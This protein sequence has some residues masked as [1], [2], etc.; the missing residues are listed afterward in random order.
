[1][2]ISDWSSDVCSSDLR[3]HAFPGVDAGGNA[4]PV[5]LDRHRTVGV[6]DDEDAVAMA[7]QRLV[8][9]VVGN[10]EHH[11]VEARS[12]VG[13]ADVHAGAFAH[14]IHALQDLDGIGAIIVILGSFILMGIAYVS[15]PVHYA[16]YVCPCFPYK[17]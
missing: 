8:D 2:R 6:E 5:V 13:V 17:K 14:G 9:G 3:R 12:V 11:V 4:A 1:M 10:L 7:G 16:L 15:P